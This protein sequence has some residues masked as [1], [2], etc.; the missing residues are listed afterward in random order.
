MPQ[1]C[2]FS[3]CCGCSACFAVCSAKAISMQAD[4][5]GF[6]H[7]S[8]DTSKC[9]NCKKCEKACPVLNRPSPREPMAVYAAQS[10]DDDLRM[11]SS[12]GGIFTLL[13]RQLFAKGG[14]VY[15]AAYRDRDKMV[16]Y[17]S[18]ENENELE[19]LR[20][21][22]Y[23]Q[24]EMGD[25]YRDVKTN[26]DN[27]RLVMFTGTPC[28]IAGLRQYL[29][30]SFGAKLSEKLEKL[31][32]VDVI[33]HAAPSPLA[34]KK[35]L[36]ERVRLVYS[37]RQPL[38]QVGNAIR[39]ISSRRKNCGWKRYSMSLR[40]ANDMEYLQDLYHDPFLQGFLRELYNRPSCHDC[41]FRELR[42]GSDLTIADYWNVAEYY[43]DMD[44]DK[45]T[46]LVLTNTDR[47]EWAYATIRGQ[48]KDKLSDYDRAVRVNPSLC[49]SPVVHKKRSLFFHK[50]DSQGFDSAVS[51]CLQL[52]FYARARL[53][54]SRL[55]RRLNLRH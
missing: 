49:F 42:S 25:V 30:V 14:I 9:I 39:R 45:G 36:E 13:A 18:A 35:Y 44:D 54:M 7:P 53:F 20:T 27:R 31:L 10:K 4:R 34:W 46:S 32:C 47:G 6:L 22:K 51:R 2:D 3:E 28:Q 16:Q 29:A 1:L 43:P 55:L 52:S 33:C 50:I 37:G 15:G 21:S 48:V 12:S 23:V 19:A 11:R 17:Q 40:F 26:L 8:I 41:K 24:S 5:E 38:P